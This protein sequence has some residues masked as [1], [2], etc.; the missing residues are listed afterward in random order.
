[1]TGLFPLLILFMA[2]LPSSPAVVGVHHSAAIR[3]DQVQHP[4]FGCVEVIWDNEEC[5]ESLSQKT[6]LN[7]RNFLPGKLAGLLPQTDNGYGCDRRYSCRTIFTGCK[8]PL[9]I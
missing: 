8:I 9:R 2:V 6:T 5:R 1:M 7:P 3:T 4:G